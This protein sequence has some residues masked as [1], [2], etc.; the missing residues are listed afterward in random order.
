MFANIFRIVTPAPLY[1]VAKNNEGE[2]LQ[3]S[4]TLF[5]QSRADGG[6]SVQLAAGLGVPAHRPKTRF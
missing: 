1:F 3:I 4:M 5:G 6:V 2:D